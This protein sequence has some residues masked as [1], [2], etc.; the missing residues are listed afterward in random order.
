MNVCDWP[1]NICQAC[2]A[3]GGDEEDSKSC[4]L[5]TES[6]TAYIECSNGSP[7]QKECPSGEV[8]DQG[9]ETCD[10]MDSI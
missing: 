3:E 10:E 2:E 5:P 4:Y 7:I 1:T 8:W 6:P 9:L